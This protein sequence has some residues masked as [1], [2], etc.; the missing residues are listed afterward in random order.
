LPLTGEAE[1]SFRLRCDNYVSDHKFT[2][3][4]GDRREAYDQDLDMAL[5]I[6]GAAAEGPVAWSMARG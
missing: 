6:A 2:L 3:H 5:S 1:L 4:L